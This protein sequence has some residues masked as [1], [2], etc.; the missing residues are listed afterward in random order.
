MLDILWNLVRHG[1]TSGALMHGRPP[2]GPAIA[3]SFVLVAIACSFAGLCYAELASMIP[4]PGSSGG[5]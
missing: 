4:V 5:T 1:S 3:V 2:A